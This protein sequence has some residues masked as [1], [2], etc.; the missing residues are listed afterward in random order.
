MEEKDTVLR[1]AQINR[2]RGLR[3]NASKVVE[4]AYVDSFFTELCW[5]GNRHTEKGKGKG[6]LQ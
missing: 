6:V 2:I 4:M 3:E 1:A 5:E